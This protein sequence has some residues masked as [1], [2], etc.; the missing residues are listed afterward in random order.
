MHLPVHIAS[1]SS[2]VLALQK[3]KWTTCA[4]AVPAAQPPVDVSA[5][6]LP[7]KAC[8]VVTVTP[9]RKRLQRGPISG[10]DTSAAVLGASKVDPPVP[11]ADIYIAESAVTVTHPRGID[12]PAVHRHYSYGDLGCDEVAAVVESALLSGPKLTQASPVG[13]LPS[14]PPREEV[15]IDRNR[16]ID[17]MAEEVSGECVNTFVLILI[18]VGAVERVQRSGYTDG[19]NTEDTHTVKS[20]MVSSP[21]PSPL[22][23][24]VASQVSVDGGMRVSDCTRTKT[25]KG[26]YIAASPSSCVAAPT[27]V[28]VLPVLYEFFVI[29]SAPQDVEPSTVRRDSPASQVYLKDLYSKSAPPSATTGAGTEQH[30]TRSKC[31]HCC[32]WNWYPVCSF[33]VVACD[34]L[35]P[36]AQHDEYANALS[37]EPVACILPAPPGCLP[38]TS[39]PIQVPC[40]HTCCDDSPEPIAAESPI[41]VASVGVAGVSRAPQPPVQSLD[42]PDDDSLWVMLPKLQEEQLRDLY[43]NMPHLGAYRA[44][45]LPGEAVETFD[46]PPCMTFDVIVNLFI[47]GALR[48]VLSWYKWGGTAPYCN[49]SMLPHPALR[50]DGRK[51]TYNSQ[52]AVAITVGVVTDCS[53]YNTMQQGGYESEAYVLG[54][55]TYHSIWVMPLSQPWQRES[56]MLG[57]LFFLTLIKSSAILP[58]GIEFSTWARAVGTSVYSNHNKFPLPLLSKKP[59]STTGKASPSVR[60]P[61]S[62]SKN[63]GLGSS[64]QHEFYHCLGFDNEVA[65]GY[66]PSVWTVSSISRE[67]RLSMNIQFVIVLG[68]AL[69]QAE[70]VS[71]GFIDA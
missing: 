5:G 22:Y 67:A 60:W 55:K 15:P 52:T 12:V 3:C 16:F 33:E 35:L 46:H 32:V 9:T 68:Q 24:P 65:V 50:S 62:P 51:A 19:Y 18:L 11:V 30:A 57:L 8:D 49:L 20:A 42:E 54:G 21:L 48:S 71:A 37:P 58:E 28:A 38:C 6:P 43:A 44:V 4:R 66:T 61:K 1:M 69:P 45:I 36:G 31:M 40:S 34:L 29:V 47:C 63:V 70:L 64:L 14:Q 7:V 39:N 25:A 59:T 41:A 26:L 53:L 17:N 56:T 2:P 13:Q 27:E 10:S 23:V